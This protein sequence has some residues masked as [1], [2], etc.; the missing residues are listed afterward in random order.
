MNKKS[1]S[2]LLLAGL[3]NTGCQVDSTKNPKPAA[4][5]VEK[6]SPKLEQEQ[7][8][9]AFLSD[10]FN[11][12]LFSQGTMVYSDDFDGELNKNYLRSKKM[13]LKDGTLIMAPA[14]KTKEEAMKKLKRDHHLGLGVVGHLNKVPEKF[15]LHMRYKFVTDAIVPARPSFQIG[16]HMMSLSYNPEG[17]YK[18]ILPGEKKVPF[19]EANAEMKINEWVDLIIE[20]QK[21]KMLLSVNGHSKVYEHPQVTMDNKKDKSGPRFSLKSKDGIEER[22]VFDSIK[23]WQAE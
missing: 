7:Q 23:L 20:Y 18:L 14:F 21:G 4:Q 5:T 1:L 9:S 16:H 12:Q 10:E 3:L 6:A 17:G 8:A 22:I 15:V 13:Y 11:S 19:I 2:L